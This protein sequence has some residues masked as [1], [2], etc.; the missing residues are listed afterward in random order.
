M[1]PF[2]L[3]TSSRAAVQPLL[4]LS[5]SISTIWP[6]LRE[7]GQEPPGE[8]K[9][10]VLPSFFHHHTPLGLKP[11]QA[12]LAGILP[13]G[14]GYRSGLRSHQN[15]DLMTANPPLGPKTFLPWQPQPP[16]H[17]QFTLPLPLPKEAPTP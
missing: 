6:D 8:R 15:L 3:R 1:S 7:S 13:L 16:C 2:W 17:Q 5:L 9:T 14:R 4:K 12:A 11:G 10:E